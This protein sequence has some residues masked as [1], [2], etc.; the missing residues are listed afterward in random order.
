MVKVTR[1]MASQLH[2]SMNEHHR[3]LQEMIDHAPNQQIKDELLLAQVHIERSIKRMDKAL[4][5]RWM[6]EE[7]EE[8]HFGKP[9]GRTL[10]SFKRG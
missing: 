3:V 9:A 1:A 10:D 2:R 8:A 5:Y 6:T 7:A 4:A